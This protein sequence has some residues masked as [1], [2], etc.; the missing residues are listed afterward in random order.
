MRKLLAMS[1]AWR[2]G[3]VPPLWRGD[4]KQRTN[5]GRF[6][7]PPPRSKTRRKPTE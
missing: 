4:E 6:V 3:L 2:R 7:A 5:A 1:P